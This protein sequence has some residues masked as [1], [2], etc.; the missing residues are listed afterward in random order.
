[1][2][3]LHGKHNLFRCLFT[4]IIWRIKL[5][6]FFNSKNRYC[7]TEKFMSFS[8]RLCNEYVLN[9][10]KTS[11]A[12]L[13]NLKYLLFYGWN[14]LLGLVK[15]INFYSYCQRHASQSDTWYARAKEFMCEWTNILYTIMRMTNTTRDTRAR[16]IS[17]QSPLVCWKYYTRHLKFL[18]T[19][20]HCCIL[21]HIQSGT[22]RI[23]FDDI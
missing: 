5:K 8:C 12:S 11:F 15:Y 10:N 7:C 14:W 6:Q 17:I 22:R 2:M 19:I 4:K 1:M 9:L 13:W 3:F 21:F 18:I 16:I 20:S 23:E